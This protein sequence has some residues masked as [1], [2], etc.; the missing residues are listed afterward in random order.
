M[1]NQLLSVAALF[2]LLQACS[3]SVE[4]EQAL[5]RDVGFY[6][7]ARE[8][9]NT[10]REVSLTHNLVV[11][12]VKKSGNS[13]FKKRFYCVPNFHVKDITLLDVEQKSSIYIATYKMDY[14]L[15]SD[16]FNTDGVEKLYAI[17]N[18]SGQNWFFIK[19][20]DLKFP[21]VAALIAIQE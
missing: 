3:L 15:F 18:S 2:F 8:E 9:C 11:A 21:D 10:L 12:N 13:N 6:V 7:S 4:Q 1:N 14:Q 19:E 17:S 20:C 5:N 16:T